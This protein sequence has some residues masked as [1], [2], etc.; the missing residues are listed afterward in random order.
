M[1][2]TSFML[3]CG[4]M[5]LAATV[6]AQAPDLNSPDVQKLKDE[7][8]AQRGEIAKQRTEAMRKV[9]DDQLEST[10]QMLSKAK[11]SGNITATAAS[12]AA[13]KLFT[14]VK[15][16]F[17]KNGSC[18]VADKVRT[19]LEAT[20]EEFKRNLRFV[21]DKQAEDIKKL[22]RSFAVKLGEILARQNTPVTDEA[23][24]LDLWTHMLPAMP[25]TTTTSATNTA[26]NNAVVAAPATSAVLQSK[27]ET[28]NW[29]TLMKLDATVRD[30]LEIVNV[31][32]TGITAPKSFSG[33]GAMGNPWQVQVSPY[34]ELATDKAPPPF[35]IQ[36][37]PPA[38]TMEVSTWPDARNNWT[39]EL[40]AKTT[41]IPSRHIILLETDAAA[42]K[43]LSGGAATTP[44]S[45]ATA[46]TAATPAPT[47][48]APPATMKV[49]F[50]SQPDGAA[51]LINNQPLLEQNQPLLT[52]FYYTMPAAPADITFR[53]RG[54]KEAI[55]RQVMPV[56]NKP[57]HV[58]LEDAI[59]VT[60]VTI[61]VPANNTAEWTPTG[62]RARKGNRVRITANGTWSCGAGG[63]QVD[64]N[65]Y[66]N[67]DTYFKYYLD[68]IQ[69]PRISTKAKYGQLIA[70]ILPD[71]EIFPIGNQ[72]VFTVMAEGEVVLAINEQVQARK[73]NQNAIKARILVDP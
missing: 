11:I 65:G 29:T 58:T 40:R 27:G 63:E 6:R 73:D 23:K 4:A 38:K 50:E 56:A 53:K 36:S 2:R 21:E 69:N 14:D 62:V 34:Q 46:G 25:V 39:I 24:L 47:P 70:R 26:G 68:P 61:P 41:K 5:F 19:D 45:T 72:G 43:P 7:A 16:S 9:I 32:L 51:V 67:D 59:G 3:F 57:I 44:P 15:T 64:A 54:Y 35:R 31:P 55:L 28:A 18:A 48:A 22:N 37:L 17:E 66:Q 1:I 20:V 49:R 60:D 30:G 10:R 42:C 12:T 71:N 13:I 33:T 8:L 52:P